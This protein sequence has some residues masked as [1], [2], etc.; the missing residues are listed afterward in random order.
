MSHVK[1]NILTAQV[2]L[3]YFPQYDLPEMGWT[4]AIQ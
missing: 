3:G 4:P 1:D 2:H